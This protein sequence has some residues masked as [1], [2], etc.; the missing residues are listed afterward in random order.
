MAE[1]PDHYEVLGVTK[2]A[3]KAEIKT[4]YQRIAMKNHPD[5]VKNKASL[6]QAQKDEAIARF[7][8][9]T[10]AEKILSD[11]GLRA[12]Y[13]KFGHKGVEN[14]LAGKSASSGQSYEQ[15]AGPTMKRTYS[16]EDT[17]DFFE[18][19]RDHR[20][21]TGDGDDDGLSPE[22]RRA[23]AR[24]ERLKRRRGGEDASPSASNTGSAANAFHDVAEK[25]SEASEKLQGGVSVPLEALEKFRE[26]LSGFLGEIDKA[27]SRAKRGPR[28]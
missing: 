26:N 21:R 15:V 9:A 2:T 13:D 20:E 14:M 25:V 10:E 22:E 16:T 23:K 4:A 11:D 17:F 6:T 5:M 12:A 8:L 18:K 7:K 1:K 28:P 27:I 24:E 3:T 19:R